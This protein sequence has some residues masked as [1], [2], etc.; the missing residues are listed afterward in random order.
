MAVS[1]SEKGLKT[2]T[3]AP[4]IDTVDIYGEKINLTDILQEF[5]GLVIDFFRG[6]W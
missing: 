5:R 4:M 6:A 2:G 1:N 3:K